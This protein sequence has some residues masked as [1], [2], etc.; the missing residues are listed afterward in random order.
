MNSPSELA[1]IEIVRLVI[2]TCEELAAPGTTDEYAAARFVE[3]SLKV[4]AVAVKGARPDTS[5]A[6]DARLAAGM[7]LWDQACT[8]DRAGDLEGLL[9]VRD[10]AVEM[11]RRAL[12]GE[13]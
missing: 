7:A 1:C 9:Q 8:A 12:N 5:D 6:V 11:A 13:I 2:A 10:R 4:A 3:M